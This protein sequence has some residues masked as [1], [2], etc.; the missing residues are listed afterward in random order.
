[1]ANGA[2]SFF[3]LYSAYKKRADKFGRTFDLTED[4]FRVITQQDCS[5]CGASP[6]QRKLANRLS[7]GAYVYNG[8]DRIDNSLGY[9]LGNV[10]AACKSCN[11]AKGTMTRKEFVA[12]AMRVALHSAG[13]D[14][15]NIEPSKR[16]A[17]G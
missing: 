6:S 12:W 13:H 4:Q 7:F 1:L 15:L 11:A 2:S 14:A 9:T 17:T 16:Y 10:A 5:Y 3:S 8:I